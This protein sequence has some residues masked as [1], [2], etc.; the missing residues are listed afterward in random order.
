MQEYGN[1]CFQVNGILIG[2]HTEPEYMYSKEIHGLTDFGL[3]NQTQ[4]A[5]S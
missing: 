5:K 1:V 3:L 4:C 2:H